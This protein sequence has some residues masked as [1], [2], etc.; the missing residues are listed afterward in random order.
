MMILYDIKDIQS[1]KIS[2]IFF[3][4]ALTCNEGMLVET[5]GLVIDLGEEEE[6]MGAS[7]NRI[8]PDKIE[9]YIRDSEAMWVYLRERGLFLFME[10][11]KGFDEHVS[12]Q[13]MD[14]WT[15]TKVT[16]NGVSFKIIEELIENV[17]GLTFED[18]R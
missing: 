9:D 7:S 6:T 8:K 17:A 11:I 5:K 15:N 12:M 4:Q 10:C 13:F 16:F 14:I 18:M 3:L 2:K 1:N